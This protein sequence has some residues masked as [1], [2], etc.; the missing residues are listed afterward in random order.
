VAAIAFIFG[1]A[2]LVADAFNSTAGDRGNDERTRDDAS[3]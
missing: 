2:V 1:A 3:A